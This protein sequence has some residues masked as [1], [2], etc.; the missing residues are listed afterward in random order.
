MFR[1]LRMDQ[2]KRITDE[3]YKRICEDAPRRLREIAD[4]FGRDEELNEFYRKRAVTHDS[5]C[6][7]HNGPALKAGECDCGAT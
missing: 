4:R 6:A 7:M 1:E 2:P 5:D 3:A